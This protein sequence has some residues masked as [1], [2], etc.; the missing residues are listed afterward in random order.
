MS[1]RV[2]Q[3]PVETVI[4]PNPNTRVSQ[5]PTETIILP[6]TAKARVSQLPIEVLYSL[7]NIGN[8]RLS[9][10]AVEIIMGNVTISAKRKYGPAVQCI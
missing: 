1:N 2:S 6:T 5:L 7:A 10:Y 3:L 4:V 9:Q 8:I